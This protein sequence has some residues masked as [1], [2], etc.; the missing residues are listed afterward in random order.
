MHPP[1]IS[2]DP[3][4]PIWNQIP[5][6]VNGK[7]CPEDFTK[8]A[9]ALVFTITSNNPLGNIP[10]G[11]LTVIESNWQ[12]SLVSSEEAIFPD[13]EGKVVIWGIGL[14]TRANGDFISKPLYQCTGDDIM[15]EI[16]GHLHIEQPP[17]SEIICRPTLLPLYRAPFQLHPSTAYPTL[18]PSINVSFIGSFSQPPRHPLFEESILQG[19]KVAFQSLNLAIP[20]EQEEE[21]MV[22]EEQ[23]FFSDEEEEN[24]PVQV[25]KRSHVGIVFVVT[26]TSLAAGFL[27]MWLRRRGN[28]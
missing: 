16:C 6:E 21:D 2:R 19:R 7:G 4:F 24:I 25:T 3:P 9:E 22:Y 12:L 13:Q 11:G 1:H 15:R 23:E 5:P 26:I 20:E 8:N 10:T 28:R 27:F 17:Q 14:N 18:D